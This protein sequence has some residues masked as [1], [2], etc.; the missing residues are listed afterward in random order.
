MAEKA[1]HQWFSYL[2]LNKIGLGNGKRMLVKDGVYIPPKFGTKMNQQ[3]QNQ[4]ALLLSV[5]SEVAQEKDLAILSQAVM[6]ELCLKARETFDAFFA[7]QMF[8]PANCSKAKY[9]RC[10]P[11]NIPGISST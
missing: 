6:M 4:V 3:Y 7:I 9:G 1:G 10:W 8:L 11:G 2:D 5:L